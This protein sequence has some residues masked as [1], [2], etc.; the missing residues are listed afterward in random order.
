M[1]SPLRI[2]GISAGDEKEVARYGSSWRYVIIVAYRSLLRLMANHCIVPSLRAS[3]FRWSGIRIGAK[4][5]INMN[6]NFLDDF[7]PGLITLEDEVSVAPLV[8][9]VASAHPNDSMLYRKYGISDSGPITVRSGA[10]L[11]V[12]CV[13]LPGVTIGRESIVGANAVVTQDVEDFALMAGV[14]AKKIG[15]VRTR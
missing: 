8:S 10:W 14:P 5:R 2:L 1:K 9:F 4:T 11:G 6:I 15:D 13:I 3:L 12:G 7:R